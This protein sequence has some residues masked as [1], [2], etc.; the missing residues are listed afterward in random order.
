MTSVISRR[1]RVDEYARLERLYLV[2]VERLRADLGRLQGEH[3][4]F[5]RL[6]VAQARTEER[7]AAL[8][9]L[10]D[11]KFVKL[12]DI[13]RAD[14]D[15]VALALTAA[16]EAVTKAEASVN[17]RLAAMNEFRQQL[18]DQATTFMPRKEAEQLLS[19][20]IDRIEAIRDAFI[21]ADEKLNERVKLL[22]Q[23]GSNLQ[24][25]IWALGAVIATVVVIVNVAITLLSK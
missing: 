17:E 25:R 3:A 7:V 19:A 11:E 1:D 13:M 5:G 2:E 14:A 12:R 22:E 6:I 16:K 24:G 9:R 20:S 21:V 23:A 8:D 4:E 10:T 18:S 15:K